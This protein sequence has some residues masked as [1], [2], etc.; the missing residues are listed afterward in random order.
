MMD[1]QAAV[2]AAQLLFDARAGR[3]PPLAALPDECAPQSVADAHR[4]QQA[5]AALFR[6]SAR[7][8]K[9]SVKDGVV[10]HGLILA[11]RILSSPARLPRKTTR[12]CGVEAEIAFRLDRELPK[13]AEPYTREEVTEAVTALVAIEIVDAGLALPDAPPLHKASDFLVNGGLVTGSEPANWRDVDLMALEA[14]LVVNGLEKKRLTGGY[15]AGHPLEPAIALIND[16]A[17]NA[18]VPAG[19]IITTGSYTGL[20]FVEPGDT[21]QVEFVGFGEAEI[22]FEG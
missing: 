22:T 12:L 9:V 10:Q 14:V 18:A 6:D 2:Q 4:I 3:R 13:R 11:S 19:F 1:D 21:V 16:L 5:L 8:M 15:A 20:D 7:A 17:T